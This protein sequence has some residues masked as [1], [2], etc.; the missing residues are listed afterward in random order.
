MIF[1]RPELL[2]LALPGAWLL[3]RCGSAHSLA[4]WL[5][6]GVAACLLVALAD[7]WASG[8]RRG[9][10]LIVVV[11]R[12]GSAGGRAER[13]LQDLLPLL[14][15]E[16]RAGDR[17][18]VI[19]FGA[20]ARVDLPPQTEFAFPGFAQAVDPD[21]S[22]LAN[23]L[24]TAL[25]LLRPDRPGSVLILSDGEAHGPDPDGPAR[26]AAAR[27]VR[28]DVRPAPRPAGPDIAVEELGLPPRVGPGE[29]F[30]FPAWIRAASGGA[31]DWT[32]LRDGV[33]I[34]SGSA[35]LRAGLNRLLLRDRARA[36]GLATYRLELRR[37][38]DPEPANDVG[39]GAVVVEGRR[40]V[41]LVNENAGR[42]RL[43]RALEGA[44]LAVDVRS[45]AEVAAWDPWRL[46][47]YAATVLENVGANALGG[48]LAPLARQVEDLGAGLLMTGGRAAFGPG[49]YYHSLLD[50]LLPVTMEMRVEQRKLGLALAVVLDRSGSMAAPIGGGRTKM[51][52][53]NAGTIE[54]VRLLSALDEVAVVVVDSEPHV[55]VPLTNADATGAIAARV[56]GIRSQGGGIYVYTG[57]QAA[58]RQLQ[59]ASRA[60]RHIILFADA[61]DAEEPGD[62]VSLLA[63]LRNRN[64]TV[65]VVALGSES[66]PDAAFL[67][68]I[69]A[70]G[71][72]EIYFSTSPEDLPRLFAQDTLLAARATF[73]EEPTATRT[74]PGLFA[75]A[76]LEPGAWC[77][78]PGY[79]LN[80]LR[81]GAARGVATTDENEAP[82]LATMQAGL[83]R[84]A[85][86]SAQVDGPFGL[87]VADWPRAARALATVAQWVASQEAGDAF[88]TTVRR[89]GREALI[90][91]EADPERAGGR[92]A[93]E[94]RAVSP[95]G[96]LQRVP[97][98]ATGQARWEAR[99]PIGMDGV[100]R[101]AA[102]TEDGRA[103]PAESLAISYSP[104]FEIRADPREGQELLGRIARISGG[105][106]DPTAAE[107]LSGARGDRATAPVGGRW[108]LAALLLLLGE[109]AWRRFGALAR[110]PAW[111]RLPRLPRR[112]RAVAPAAQAPQPDA[113][114][115][116]AEPAAPI[117]PP[118]PQPGPG[119]DDAL[120]AAKKKA[121]RRL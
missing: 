3:A 27:G 111:L 28:V 99:V 48:M 30:A 73:V 9:R 50:P 82:I 102:A 84:T 46:E 76:A 29:A 87:S 23:A 112:A 24:D 13:A 55:I 59:N 114:P 34:A 71:G 32:L 66:D 15:D 108:V 2:L 94:I 12:S 5:R 105:R 61:A 6:A 52:L 116:A 38:G 10:D 56:S 40:P 33:P 86:F 16:A 93:V 58:A 37:Q 67:R 65:S 92:G 4:F 62:T 96:A 1:L 68:D 95:D 63:S 43:A 109:I 14:A 110:R 81:P 118:L 77:T 115:G 20:D 91:V 47:G 8:S 100:Y 85:A 72:G 121:R 120:A 90:T 104:E 88:F 60:N 35:E 41:L 36:P 19:G 21:G 49:G 97:L 42:G 103:L 70:R 64:T 17:L 7:P 31:A 53:A 54:A 75:V 44:G 22:H 107:I 101:F 11:D 79:N 25:A 98:Q 39:L 51:D 80:Y 83:G 106:V 57:L 26:R 117:A 74:T 18:A 89:E 113:P 119:V 69:A 78:L 45:P